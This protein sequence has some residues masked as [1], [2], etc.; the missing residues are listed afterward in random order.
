MAKEETGK[1]IAERAKAI[2]DALVDDPSLL[3]NPDVITKMIADQTA[4]TN[5][6]M[7]SHSSKF[8][9]HMQ[10]CT[11]CQD[12]PTNLCS[13]GKPLFKEAVSTPDIPLLTPEIELRLRNARAALTAACDEMVNHT[14]PGVQQMR[15]DACN[16]MLKTSMELLDTGLKLVGELE[17]KEG[18]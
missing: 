14:V 16:R 8:Y 3:S 4:V 2:A 5:R 15:I 11:D 6:I 12:D 13:V 18:A 7:V 9:D 17:E 1:T 10:T